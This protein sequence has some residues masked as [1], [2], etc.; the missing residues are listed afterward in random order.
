MCIVCTSASSTQCYREYVSSA[1]N[2]PVYTDCLYV[3]VL[4]TA[5]S[6]QCYRE[7]VS[8]AANWVRVV[9]SS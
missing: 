5:S 1:A 6:T 9:D 2:W 7:Y 8:S 3:V 4:A